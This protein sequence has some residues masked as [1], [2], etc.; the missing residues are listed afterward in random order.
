MALGVAEN[1]VMAGAATTEARVLAVRL[2]LTEL[3]AVM[4]QVPGRAGAVQTPSEVMLPALAVQMTAGLAA[5]DTVAAN[6]VVVDTVR[7][8]FTG[9]TALRLTA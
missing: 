3:V 6:E 5:P 8:G 7:I 1:W 2:G 9:V 4:V